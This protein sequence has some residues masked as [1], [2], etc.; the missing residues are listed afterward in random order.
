MHFEDTN[1]P[2]VLP[3][4]NMPTPDTARVYP[5]G[6]LVEGTNLSEGRGTTRPFELVGAP[7]LDGPDLAASL[8][9]ENLPGVLFRATSFRPMFQKHAGKICAGVQVHVIDR[10]RFR[11]FAA[12]L[13]LLRETRRQAGGDFGWRREPYEFES[14]RLAIDLLLGRSDLRSMIEGNAPLATMEASWSQGLSEFLRTRQ[15]FL[16]YPE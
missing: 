3:S 16:L 15:R 5:G 6:C 4:P 13:L 10:E 12:Y 11:P 14:E 9:D 8:R 2:W 1:L 7:W